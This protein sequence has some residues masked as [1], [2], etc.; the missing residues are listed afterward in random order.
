MFSSIKTTLI[1][2]MI[3]AILIVSVSVLIFAV[4][5]HE[6]LYLEAVESDLD[7]LSTNM[8]DDIVGL[9]AN[10]PD[11]F[12]LAIPL[13]RLD[14]YDNVKYASILDGEGKLLHGY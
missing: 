10:D 12:E 14:R 5:E 8:A 9:M 4:S 7:A 3:S 1:A 2:L 11:P 6:T 13:L